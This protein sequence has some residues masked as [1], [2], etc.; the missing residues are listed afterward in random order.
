MNDPK[1]TLMNLLKD[2]WNL[3]ET[4]EFASDWYSQEQKLP[5]IT[6]SHV[7]TTP[8][9]VGLS[10][11]VSTNTRRHSGNYSVDVWSFDQES[12]W[13]MIQE[14]DRIVQGHCREPGGGLEFIEV[15]SWRDLDEGGRRP[16]VYRSQL[17]V[18]VHYYG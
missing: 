18:K 16:P 4:P 6:V 12:R 8:R 9:L 2:S 10:E 7:I 13:S 3:S 11:D 5:Q 17:Q 1:V 15:G 14:V